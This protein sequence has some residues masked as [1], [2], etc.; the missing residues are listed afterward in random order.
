MPIGKKAKIRDHDG[1]LLRPGLDDAG[2]QG[3]VCGSKR[4]TAVENTPQV[5]QVLR[6]FL[7]LSF[8]RGVGKMGTALFDISCWSSSR[9]N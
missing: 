9:G 7:P 4:L 6:G 8:L 5:R 1:L 2:L 3:D